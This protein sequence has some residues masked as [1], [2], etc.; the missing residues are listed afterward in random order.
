MKKAILAL[1]LMGVTSL[2]AQ[3][4]GERNHRQALRD[5]SPEQ[6]ATLKT[7]KM[8]LALDLTEAQQEQVR[9]LHL[10]NAKLRKSKM[11]EHK[12]RKENNNDKPTIDERY[13]MQIERLDNQIAHKAEMKTIL[14]AEQYE[15]W[16]KMQF[17]RNQ[18]RKKGMQRGKRGRS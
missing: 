8:T 13:A 16:E 6:V 17:H 2:M 3:E 15:K 7:K 9:S 4:R 5:L 14:S 18:Q 1:C 10:E 12:Q 11:E